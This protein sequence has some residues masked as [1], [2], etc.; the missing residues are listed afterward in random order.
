[1][2]VKIAKLSKS[3]NLLHKTAESAKSLTIKS[4]ADWR[5]TLTEDRRVETGNRR[6]EKDPCNVLYSVAQA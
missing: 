3:A 6:W 1:M 2:S 5:L 4:A